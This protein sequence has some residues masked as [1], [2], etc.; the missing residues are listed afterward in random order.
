MPKMLMGQIDHARGRVRQITRELLGEAPK[1][2]AALHVSDM[3][4]ALRTGELSF[5]GKQLL[6][7]VNEWTEEYAMKRS[8]YSSPSLEAVLLK[9]AFIKSRA[10]EE[11]KYQAELEK[12]RARQAKVNAEATKVEDAIVLGDQHAALAALQSFAKFKP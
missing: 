3:V 11:E 4:Q 2:P 9:N 8:T 7:M 1:K 5:S 10:V 6:D 12:Y